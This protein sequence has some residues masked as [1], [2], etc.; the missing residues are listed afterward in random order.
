VRNRRTVLAFTW[1]NGTKELKNK[2]TRR[3]RETKEKRRERKNGPL[4]NTADI[5]NLFGRR[6]RLRTFNGAAWIRRRPLSKC[7]YPHRITH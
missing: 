7:L 1:G 6:L 3:S 5:Y 4:I 2:K